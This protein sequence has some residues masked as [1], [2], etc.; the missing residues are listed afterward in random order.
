MGGYGWQN[1][2]PFQWGGGDTFEERAYLALRDAVGD[3]ASAEDA[4]IEDAW[5]RAKAITLGALMASGDRA[6]NQ[7]SPLLATD[8]LTYYE[9]LLA[10]A[11]SDEQP[12]HERNVEAAQR[13]TS[14]P[15]AY[16]AAAL[17]ELHKID[18]TFA[19]LDQGHDDTITTHEGRT[20]QDWAGAIPYGGGRTFSEYGFIS[21]EYI[22]RFI[23]PIA[24]AP[25]ATAIA[26]IAKARQ[27]LHDI[28]PAWMGFSIATATGFVLDSSSL[29]VTGFG[30]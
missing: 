27:R 5:R 21:S 10:I 22:F 30:P 6:A 15:Y 25:D 13:F 14:L 16:A 8:F 9:D 19:L 29:D 4:T 12:T 23:L 7:G 26:K 1:G 3:L 20:F 17:A 11:S 24:G 2:W 18:A 28:L